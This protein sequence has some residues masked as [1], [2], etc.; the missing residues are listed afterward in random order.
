ML[1]YMANPD[2]G[3]EHV[4]SIQ[5]KLN[6]AIDDQGWLHSEDKGALSVR[7]MVKITGRF[8]EIIIGAAGENIAP[9]PVED[10]F[11]ELCPAVSNIMM[12]GDKR[13]FNTALLTLQAG[14]TG[15]EPGGDQ[16][17][18][19]AVGY[20]DGVTTIEEACGSKEFID[21]IIQALKD[22]NA[23]H[24]ACPMNASKVQRF[25][26]LPRDF[27]ISGEELTATLKL[28]RSVVVDKYH[29]AIER[30]YS[31]DRGAVFVPFNNDAL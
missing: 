31:A 27:S 1:G 20:V 3:E 25:T 24:K 21:K 7:G 13:K 12:I 15:T 16:L 10:R 19:T 18:G 9:V 8:K 2:L 17:T 29:N 5:K 23:D 6:E 4:L 28:K 11:K 14:G 30:M 22:T 26:I